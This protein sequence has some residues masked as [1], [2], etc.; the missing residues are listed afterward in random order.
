MH[1]AGSAARYGLVELDQAIRTAAAEAQGS[2]GKEGRE[3]RSHLAWLTNQSAAALGQL[4]RVADR[5]RKH[6]GRLTPEQVIAWARTLEQEQREALI[7]EL[8][9]IQPEGKGLFG[10]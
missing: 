8:Q 3:A 9:E 2:A 4:S 7:E 1:R 5:E 6:S 10:S